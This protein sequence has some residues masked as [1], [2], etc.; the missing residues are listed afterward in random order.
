MRRRHG[1]PLPPA[2]LTPEQIQDGVQWAL[3]QR[4]ADRAVASYCTHGHGRSAVLMCALLLAAGEVG[5]VEE[6]RSRV[7]AARPGAEPNKRQW[8]A[9]EHWHQRYGTGGRG[10]GGSRGM[11]G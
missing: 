6:A 5:S 11:Q 2:G 1:A 9:L 3:A 4:K 7:K 8:A 10:G